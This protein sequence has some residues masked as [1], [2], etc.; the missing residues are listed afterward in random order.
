MRVEPNGNRPVKLTT[1][2]AT[3][4]VDGASC[5]LITQLYVT[6]IAGGTPSLSVEIYDGT[7]SFYVMRSKPMTARSVL[8]WDEIPLNI[9]QKLRVTASVANQ[10]DVFAVVAERG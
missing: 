10:V 8:T 6:E 4:I 7:T 3:D 5:R 2:G 9:N 1:T